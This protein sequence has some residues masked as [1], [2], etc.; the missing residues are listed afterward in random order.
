M[1]MTT[2]FASLALAATIGLGA[3]SPAMADGHRWGRRDHAWGYGSAQQGQDI[4]A[5]GNAL[6]I[7]QNG[8]GNAANV[9]QRGGGATTITQNGNN[10]SVTVIQVIGRGH[11]GFDRGRFRRD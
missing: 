1:R 6:S 11:G 8:N 9:L 10:N 3:L 4:Q 7:T 5:T 2:S